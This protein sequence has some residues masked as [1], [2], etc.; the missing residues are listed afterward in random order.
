MLHERRKVPQE[1]L[2]ALS[3][4]LDAEQNSD[5]A[6]IMLLLLLCLKLNSLEFNGNLNSLTHMRCLSEVVKIATL[7]ISAIASERL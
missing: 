7:R 1:I 4:Y 2:N 6:Y 5:E 3:N